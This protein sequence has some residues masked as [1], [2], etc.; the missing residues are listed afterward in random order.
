MPTWKYPKKPK[1]PKKSA[2]TQTWINYKNRLKEWEKKC[3]QIDANKKAHEKA[4]AEAKKLAQ[5]L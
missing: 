3:K 4:V 5:K 2:S 1:A